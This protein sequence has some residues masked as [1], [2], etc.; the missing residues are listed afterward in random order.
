MN[1]TKDY[2]SRLQALKEEMDGITAEVKAQR[3]AEAQ[4]RHDAAYSKSFWD[5]MYT[6]IPENSLKEGSD[7]SGGYLVPDVYDDKLVQALE[8]NNFLRSI[9]T[10]ITTKHDLKIPTVVSGTTA[11]WVDESHAYQNS[12]VTFGQ[13]VISAYKLGTRVLVSNELLEDSGIDL[14]AHLMSEFGERIGK[15]EEEAFLVGN[16]DGKPTGLIYQAPVG[17]ITEEVGK[18]SMDDIISLEQSVRDSYR[19]RGN[20]VFVMSEQAYRELIKIRQARGIYIW[21]P[22]FRKDGYETLFGHRVYVSHAMDSDGFNIEPGSIPVLFGDFSYFWIGDR[23]KRNIKRLTE[24]YADY[25]Q[26]GFIASQRV[27]AKLVLPEA[28]KALKIKA[29]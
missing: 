4:R 2:E 27:D 6:G 8:E 28:V 10:V 11:Q 15:A 23:G 5:H 17:A 16:G 22:D 12:D 21:N 19:K 26:V 20:C 18:I 13:I 24:R 14:E 1:T 3:A 9:S 7:G 29:E 25:G